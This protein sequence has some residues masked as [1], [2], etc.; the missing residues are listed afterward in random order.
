MRLFRRHRPPVVPPEAVGPFDGFTAADA[1]ALQRSFVAALH[2]GERA[3]RQ[4]V[5]GTIEIGRGAAGRLVVIWRNLV[6]GFVPPDRAAPFDAAL[7]A[8][9]RA[10]VAV[11]GVVHHADGLWRVWVGDLPADGFPPPPPGLDTLPVPE[12]TVLGIR[13]DRRGENGP[14]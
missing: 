4:D 10:V 6:V 13:L 5:P 12:D 1:P 11:D 7:P 2:I 3:E 8:D 9:P 14:A